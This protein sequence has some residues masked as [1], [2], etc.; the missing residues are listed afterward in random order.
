[1]TAP[2]NAE[3]GAAAP[4]KLPGADGMPA[5][6]RKCYEQGV[7]AD[8]DNRMRAVE[9]QLFAA[10]YQWPAQA[11]R[12]RIADNRPCLTIDRI[13][14]A[15]R[16]VTGDVRLNKPAIVVSPNGS[17]SSKEIADIYSGLIRNIEQVSDADTAYTGAH[18]DAT[19][20][21]MGFWR[22]TTQYSD[23]DAFDQDIRI[24]RIA[25]PF[26]VIF[27]PAAKEFDRS[28][29]RW[30]I[31]TWLMAKD[32]FEEKYPGKSTTGFEGDILGSITPT[33]AWINDWYTYD[34]VR[35]AELWIKVPVRRTLYLLSDGEVIGDDDATPD[36][37]QQYIASKNQALMQGV[38]AGADVPPQGLP[39]VSL[40]ATREVETHK[41]VQY[42]VS[43][44]DLLEEPRDWAGRYIPIV[45]VWGR[46]T[47]VG[48]KV[49]R[50]G[51][52]RDAKDAQRAYNYMRSASVEVMALQ[53]K[54]PYLVTPKMVSGQYF[55]WWMQSGRRNFPFLP[56][57]PDPEAP[58]VKPERVQP[59]VSA[60]GLMAES[61]AAADD[62]KATTGIFDASLGQRSNET[63]GKAIMAR[64]REGDVGSYVYTDNLS[65]AIAYTGRQLVDLIPKI[66]D[67]ERVIRVM[68]EDGED[69]LVPINKAVVGPDGRTHYLN[70]LTVGEYVVTVKSGPAFSTRREEA[71]E[72]LTELV[73]SFPAA[74]PIVGDILVKQYDM[75]DGD[76]IAARLKKLLPP[77]VADEDDGAPPQPPPPNPEMMLQ[78]QKL[79]VEKQKIA[80]DAQKTQTEAQLQE[81]EHAMRAKEIEAKTFEVLANHHNQQA[82]F[83][84]NERQRRAQSRTNMMTLATAKVSPS[85][86]AQ[87]DS[88]G[89]EAPAQEQEELMLI[90]VILQGQQQTQQMVAMLAQQMQQMAA[91]M[92]APKRVLFDDSGRPAGVETVT[93]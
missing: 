14:P 26:S 75:P 59:P 33:N 90:Q 83:A 56:Y 85:A 37:V 21:G 45:G 38:S 25:D 11:E 24:K 51:M 80:A 54:A 72:K 7:S 9:D 48:D 63:S 89:E 70:D 43:G 84:E 4:G 40:K 1:M 12:E 6:V 67:A 44:S 82:Q 65:K 52:V 49:V 39:F 35:I 2:A 29:A 86:P 69:E 17:E 91:I 19:A 60:T 53:P 31:V 28:D 92:T 22:I 77:G 5:Y 36:M 23:D 57:M 46:E 71:A 93:H 30:C 34:A 27:D 74:G 55:D 88:E 62:V 68:H 15:I 73:R 87:P 10:G 61:L 50:R 79:E 66:Y 13:G 42:V 76:K 47:H 18:E 81:R 41:V 8:L 20:I 32:A 3:V 78:A 64:Q 16:Q 58:G